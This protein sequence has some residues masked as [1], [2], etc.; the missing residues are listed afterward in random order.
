MPSE[1][2]PDWQRLRSLFAQETPSIL[3]DPLDTIM[4][5]F[6]GWWGQYADKTFIREKRKAGIV[7]TPRA[8]SH[9]AAIFLPPQMLLKKRPI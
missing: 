5:L 9:Y 8:W 2:T 4:G 3:G 1:T 7:S 6:H